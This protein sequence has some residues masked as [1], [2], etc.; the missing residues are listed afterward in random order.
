MRAVR[1]YV[2]TSV[3]GGTEDDEFAGSSRRFFER[4]QRG[5]YLVVVSRALIREIRLAPEPVRQI[6]TAL[7]SDKLEFVEID[8]EVESLADAYIAAGVVGSAS[9][10]DAIHVAAA[11][12]AGADLVLSWN[13]KHIV[14]YDRIHKYNAVNLL[15][16]YRQIDIRSPMELTHGEEV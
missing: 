1:V 15:N 8:S 10:G 9:R 12:V 4:A 2:D 13:F 3:F 11:T 5:N 16:G 7:G 6:L 14:N